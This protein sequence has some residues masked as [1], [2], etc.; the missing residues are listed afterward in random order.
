MKIPY[1]KRDTHAHF[2]KKSQTQFFL[3]LLLSWL[4]LSDIL[5]RRSRL[6]RTTSYPAEEKGK[7]SSRNCVF[8]CFS[9]SLF[10]HDFVTPFSTFANIKG[11]LPTNSTTPDQL[12][13]CI[14]TD[15]E[16]FP[17]FRPMIFSNIV[18]KKAFWKGPASSPDLHPKRSP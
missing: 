10:W 2:W 15:G 9:S 11:S 16:E 7:I 1:W 8:F 14:K 17:G 5:S 18:A 6:S 4:F 12:R 3:L 13:L